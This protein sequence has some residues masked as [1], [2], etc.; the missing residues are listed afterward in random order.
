MGRYPFFF[1]LFLFNFECSAIDVIDDTGKTIMLAKPA[2]RVITLAPHLA[3]M[4]YAI[5]KGDIVVAT[6]SYSDF[7]EQAKKIPRLG[8]FDNTKLETILSFKPDLIL[9]WNSGNNLQ[10]LAVMERFGLT[11]YRDD[12]KKVQDVARTIR[13]IGILSGSKDAGKIANEFLKKLDNIEKK[14]QNREIIR[15]FYQFWDDPVY[16]VN[17]E[18]YITDVLGICGLQNVFADMQQLS[19]TVDREAVIRANPEM[20]LAAG[21]NG[22]DKKWM[23][24]WQNWKEIKAVKYHNLFTVNPDWLHRHTPRLLLATEQICHYADQARKNMRNKKTD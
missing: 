13:N 2:K 5:N 11:V 6:V 17:R 18:H 3:E 22:V 8:S 20:V 10:Q 1:I 23:E 7:P 4:M 9:A 12:P 16:T 15:V 24:K 21:M 19:A 14:Y